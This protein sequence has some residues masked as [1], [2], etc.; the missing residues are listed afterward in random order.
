MKMIQIFL[1]NER[2]YFCKIITNN[3]GINAFIMTEKLIISKYKIIGS[4]GNSN[5]IQSK[6]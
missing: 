2:H 4:L 5:A 1:I 6:F 3:N